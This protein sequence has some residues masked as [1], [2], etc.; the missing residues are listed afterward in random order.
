MKKNKTIYD[1][2]NIVVALKVAYC[3]KCTLG[4][5]VPSNLAK[6]GNLKSLGSGSTLNSAKSLELLES[7][8]PLSLK[9]NSS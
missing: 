2:I 1:S 5:L 6:F 8:D 3:L 7:W 4:S 9:A